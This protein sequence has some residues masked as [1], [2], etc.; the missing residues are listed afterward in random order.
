MFSNPRSLP[1]AGICLYTATLQMTPKKFVLMYSVKVKGNLTRNAHG[2]DQYSVFNN[3][4]YKMQLCS[5]TN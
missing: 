4:I 1:F 2:I 3:Y 5:S